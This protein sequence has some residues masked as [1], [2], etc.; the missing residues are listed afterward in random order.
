MG[1]AGESAAGEVFDRCKGDRRVALGEVSLTVS[2]DGV[3]GNK[4]KVGLL[5]GCGE[6]ALLG[7]C[8]LAWASSSRSYHHIRHRLLHGS[9]L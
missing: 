2:R 9:D 8:A 1:R 7:L 4:E 5:V 6:V 3:L